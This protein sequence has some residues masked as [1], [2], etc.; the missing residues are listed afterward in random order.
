MKE[1]NKNE[2]NEN[3]FDRYYSQDA[4][5][6]EQETEMAGYSIYGA[7]SAGSGCCC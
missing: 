3:L 2:M 7:Y 1:Q 4:T 5:A 6:E